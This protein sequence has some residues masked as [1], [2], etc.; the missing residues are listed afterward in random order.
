[1]SSRSALEREGYKA[2]E[3]IP[4][5]KFRDETVALMYAD[6]VHAVVERGDITGG[7]L[8]LKSRAAN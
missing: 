3:L 4:W 6:F 7:H 8:N 5:E 1:M 2:D